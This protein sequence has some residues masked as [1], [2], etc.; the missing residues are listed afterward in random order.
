LSYLILIFPVSVK[1]RA[2]VSPNPAW[3]DLTAKEPVAF[4]VPVAPAYLP[5]PP[6][7]VAVPV[8]VTVVGDAPSAAH[9]LVL[10]LKVTFN[11]LPPPL[12]TPEPSIESHWF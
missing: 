7:I 1:V 8:R 4:S 9:P 11:V 6:V 2:V 3:F 10:E 5:V 12:K